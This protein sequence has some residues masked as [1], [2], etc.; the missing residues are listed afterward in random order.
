VTKNPSEYLFLG[1]EPKGGGTNWKG[2]CKKSGG[3][4]GNLLLDCGLRA[5][6][7]LEKFSGKGLDKGQGRNRGSKT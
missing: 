1:S 2:V 7:F 3:R 4:G 5:H 6:T